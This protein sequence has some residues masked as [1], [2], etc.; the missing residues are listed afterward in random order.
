VGE[1]I[2]GNGINLLNLV[3]I[4]LLM[5]F[6]DDYCIIPV[7]KD[8]SLIASLTSFAESDPKAILTTNQVR[9][10]QKGLSSRQVAFNHSVDGWPNLVL[11]DGKLQAILAEDGVELPEEVSFGSEQWERYVHTFRGEVLDTLSRVSEGRPIALNTYFNS[12]NARVLAEMGFLV[13][14]PSP[15]LVERFADKIDSYALASDLKVPTIEGCVV[16]S[17]EDAVDFFSGQIRQW[18]QGA[19]V[20]SRRGSG[21]LTARHITNI[22][23]LKEFKAKPPFLITRWVE[24]EASPNSQI[25]IGVDG[26]KYLGITD[27]IIVNG[28]EYYGNTFPSEVNQ[29]K[30]DAIEHFS[31]ILGNY[32]REIG[33]RGFCG[34]DWIVTPEGRGL[35]FG[36]INPRKNR[37]SSMLV[38]A[39]EKNRPNGV[40]SITELEALASIGQGW[41]DTP[42]W[43]IEEGIYWGM[44][45]FKTW[46]HARVKTNILP[47]YDD[48]SIFNCSLGRI[49]VL[50]FP[51][52][53]T[54]LERSPSR[55]DLARIISTGKSKEEVERRIEMGRR[56]VISSYDKL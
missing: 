28:V 10:P 14:G 47:N 49:S 18:E 17:L 15:E 29:R 9:L 37:S 53:G 38:S 55:H 23:E 11:S 22:K 12:E 52:K 50:N 5:A 48:A 34:F 45:L 31:L 21:G 4:P 20:A 16:G 26:V 30:Q 51:P 6:K 40:P 25:L 42:E 36:E 33:Y 39:L 46:G 7:S 8:P 2:F 27:Q 41:G 54:Y 19:F 13:L 24:K 56:V 35:Y 44:R 1:H 43:K 32:M 3:Y